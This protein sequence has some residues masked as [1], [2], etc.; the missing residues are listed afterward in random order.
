MNWRFIYN[1]IDYKIYDA[2]SIFLILEYKKSL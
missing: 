1:P 2:E